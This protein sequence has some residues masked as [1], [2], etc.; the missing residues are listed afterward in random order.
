[1]ARAFIVACTLFLLWGLCVHGQDCGSYTDCTGCAVQAGCG[2]C[3]DTSACYIGYSGGPTYGLCRDWRWGGA[4][5]CS[6]PAPNAVC[7]HTTCANCVG[8]AGCGWCR[9]DGQCH[10]KNSTSSEPLNGGCSE[11]YPETCP[12]NG[13]QDCELYNSCGSCVS[14]GSYCQWCPTSG[15]CV[16]TGSISPRVC[17]SGYVGNSFSCPISP[18]NHC[19]DQTDCYGC[20]AGENHGRCS[21]CTANGVCYQTNATAVCP[22]GQLRND[23][24][25]APPTYNACSD[26]TQCAECTGSAPMGNC[27]WCTATRACHVGTSTGPAAGSCPTGSWEWTSNQC[28]TETPMTPRPQ[29]GCSSLYGCDSCTQYPGCGWCATSEQGCYDGDNSGPFGGECQANWRQ[30]NGSCTSGLSC[31][32]NTDCGSCTATAGCGWCTRDNVCIPGNEHGPLSGT[33]GGGNW[34]LHNCERAS[35]NLHSTCDQCTAASGCGWC[36]TTSSCTG[37]VNAGPTDGS[38]CP[39]WHFQTAEC[40]TGCASFTDCAACILSDDCGWCTSTSTCTYGG[41]MSSSGPDSGYCP[42]GD[43]INPDGVCPVPCGSYTSCYDCTTSGYGTCGWCGNVQACYAG[44]SSGPSNGECSAS[45]S[46]YSTECVTPAPPSA[47]CG[48]WANCYACTTAASGNCGWCT[49]N[50]LC[51]Q[52]TGTGPINGQCSGTWEWTSGQ[53]V[54]PESVALRAVASEKGLKPV[55]KKGV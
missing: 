29:Q 11:W 33:C 14:Q 40:G 32:S 24:C 37:G 19:G 9:T 47:D 54:D 52:G 20:L 1:M 35:C 50:K 48:Q 3:Q 4:Y 5:M 28:P 38:L 12:A 8:E 23:T 10:Q 41:S 15:T 42:A 45:W 39:N 46:W 53:C 27:G 31:S 36:S 55:E 16:S 26:Y 17:G 7:P 30:G 13:G 22:D 21:W 18:V 34:R 25:L 49:S 51:S 6:T 2:W 43:W 44:T